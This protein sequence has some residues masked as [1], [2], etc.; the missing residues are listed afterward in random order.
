M[1]SPISTV[2]SQAARSRRK[3][4]PLDQEFRL[5]LARAEAG[6]RITAADKA[7][8]RI[9]MLST[10]LLAGRDTG[11]GVQGSSQPPAPGKHTC[12]LKV[13]TSDRQDNCH[14]ISVQT[15]QSTLVLSF[16]PGVGHY[17]FLYVGTLIVSPALL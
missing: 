9:L 3:S 1:Q 10:H 4:K 12:R 14:Y 6:E 7:V 11:S 8:D 15:N 16:M 5:I 17:I 13:Y 2:L